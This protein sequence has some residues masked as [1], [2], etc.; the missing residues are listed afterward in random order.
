MILAAGAGTRFGEPK[1]S[2]LVRPGTRF[3]DAVVESARDAGASHILVVG[4]PGLAM[5]ARAVLVANARATGEQIESV[6]LGLARLA[7]TSVVGAL[8]WP[9]DHPFVRGDTARALASAARATR[10]PIALPVH[11]GRRGHPAW[12]AR[13][14]WRELMTVADGGARTVVRAYGARVLEVP[15]DDAGVLR[16][17]DTRADLACAL[18]S[19]RDA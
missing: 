3:V 16:D 12:F 13:E 14:T 10:A 8:V 18:E 19:D 4:A 6:R 5:P 15:V 1:A 2:A 17:V 11:A 7:N 9:V